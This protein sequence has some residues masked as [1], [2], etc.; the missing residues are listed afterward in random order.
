[1]RTPGTVVTNPE[2]ELLVHGEDRGGV[3]AELRPGTYR[4]SLDT[5]DQARRDMHLVC[6]GALSEAALQSHEAKHRDFRF[7]TH[8]C[9]GRNE[10]RRR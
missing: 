4:V 9:D 8:G 3:A 6:K 2:K 5:T 10:R 1:M 7:D